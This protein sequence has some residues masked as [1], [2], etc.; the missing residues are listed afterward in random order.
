MGGFKDLHNGMLLYKQNVVSVLY[1]NAWKRL[2]A[3][4][5]SKLAV[6]KWNWGFCFN[7]F[8]QRILNELYLW[9]IDLWESLDWMSKVGDMG[10]EKCTFASSGRWSCT[11]ESA[12]SF[13]GLVWTV[14]VS[15]QFPFN[16]PI[17][18]YILLWTTI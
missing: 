2:F 10:V 7:L 17:V 14:K 18:L 13:W 3:V 9:S 12:R 16:F 15:L 5:L 6:K 11:H 8:H 1:S 4:G